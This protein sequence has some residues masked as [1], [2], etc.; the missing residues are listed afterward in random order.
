VAARPFL[1]GEVL[2][3]HFPDGRRVLGG[4]PFNVAWHL[5]A[6]GQRPLLISAVGDDPQGA[7]VREAMEKWSM[8]HSALQIHPRQPTGRVQVSIED[9]EPRYEIVHPVAW[10][11]IEPLPSPA[12]GAGL[13][14]HG[15]LALR[16]DQSSAT[17]ERLRTDLNVTVFLDVNLRPPWYDPQRVLTSLQHAQWAKLN[18]DEFIELKATF[19]MAEDGRAWRNGARDCLDAWDLE[20]LIVTLGPEGAL[21]LTRDG[22]EWEAPAASSDDRLVDT[23]GAGDAFSSVM[24]VGL[25]LGWELEQSLG[26]ALE[27]AAAVCG[28]R[29]ATTT[30]P[31]FYQ[32]FV[33]RWGLASQEAPHV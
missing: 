20:A 10:D 18:T 27:F 7:A 29:G 13:L 17:L 32:E 19:G 23:V 33:R 22:A 11:R 9:D 8:D 12:P 3:D 28:Q 21:L 14:Y 16:D 6:F 30:D 26:R 4:A 31:G 15:S 2:F 25:L 1:F 5:Q 24:I